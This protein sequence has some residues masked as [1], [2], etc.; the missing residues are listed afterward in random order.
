MDIAISIA[1]DLNDEELALFNENYKEIHNLELK[2]FEL[3]MAK[4]YSLNTN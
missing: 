4:L 2:I 1:E 3:C